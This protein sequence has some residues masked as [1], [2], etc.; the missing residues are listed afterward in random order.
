MLRE[1]EDWL[2]RNRGDIAAKIDEG[3]AA[4]Q[5]GE[6]ID[7]DQV[8]TAMPSMRGGNSSWLDEAR[9]TSP[10]PI[11]PGPFWIGFR[12]DPRTFGH[13]QHTTTAGNSAASD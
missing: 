4:A 5:R 2:S 1:E 9:G 12:E 8:R 11:D 6:P 13:S 10:A 3:Y 7:E